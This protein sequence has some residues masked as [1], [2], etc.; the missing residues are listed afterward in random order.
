MFFVFDFFI[1]VL[2]L[3]ENWILLKFF[4]GLEKNWSNFWRPTANFY[5]E[6]KRWLLDFSI[7][8]SRG[9]HQSLVIR[10]LYTVNKYKKH[11]KQSAWV[12]T[13]PDLH[14]WRATWGKTLMS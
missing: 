13:V 14:Q 6:M 8:L 1:I 10:V 3:N 4:H 9:Q 5:W 12:E 2:K 11:T 7:W